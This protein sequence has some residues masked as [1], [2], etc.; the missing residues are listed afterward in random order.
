MG[1]A[2]AAA[3]LVAV[4]VLPPPE[5]QVTAAA[6]RLIDVYFEQIVRYD[7]SGALWPPQDASVMSALK[8]IP[9]VTQVEGTLTVPVVLR[10]G[11]R[12][13]DTALIGL[14]RDSQLTGI[15]AASGGHLHIRAG[16]VLLSDPVRE[17][18][19]L[20]TGDRVWVDYAF[21]SR[22]LRLSRSVVVGPRIEKPVGA[23]AYMEIG[24]VRRLF[25]RKLG[26]PDRAVDSVLMACEP[27]RRGFV[28]HRMEMIPGG[29][30]V[31]S[32]ARIRQQIDEQRGFSY[33]F[34]S[35]FVLF[36]MFLASAVIFDTMM[37]NV[38]E[39]A[40][41]VAMLRSLGFSMKRSRRMT[42]VEN[43]LTGALGLLVG[44]PTGY[45]LN[46]W[47]VQMFQSESCRLEPVSEPWVYGMAVVGAVIAVLVGQMPGLRHLA[48][49][50]LAEMPR[51]MGE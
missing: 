48:R 46:L 1:V 47:T 40:R 41:E 33:M 2:V 26:M 16:E 28:Q 29:L 50:N 44:L 10:S 14:A 51:T 23:E 49:M 19:G 30:A 27:E 20:A 13:F 21:N 18:L 32:P 15:V 42:T 12:R 6:R 34:T 5:V 36:G 3:V 25:G 31:D 35:L 43:L 45:G 39:R 37:V 11:E 17:R 8:A 7:A 9:G 24:E 38:F 4:V 22:E